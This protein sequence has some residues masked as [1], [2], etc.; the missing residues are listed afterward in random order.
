L[1]G[2]ILGEGRGKNELLTQRG[3]RSLKLCLC[4][5]CKEFLLVWSWWRD[6]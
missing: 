1:D 4:I 3:G 2:L 6:N 5:C